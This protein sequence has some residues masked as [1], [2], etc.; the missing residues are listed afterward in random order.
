MFYKT[1]N[2]E[3]EN[4][5]CLLFPNII[6]CLDRARGNSKIRNICNCE[7]HTHIYIHIRGVPCW[8]IWAITLTPAFHNSKILP[9][10]QCF[11]APKYYHKHL[12]EKSGGSAIAQIAYDGTPLIEILV[13]VCPC[14]NQ[15]LQGHTKEF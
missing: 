6:I 14:G 4:Y 11:S 2:F 8:S 15:A 1:I 9:L 10:K 13:S 12:Y 3:C 7:K 5:A